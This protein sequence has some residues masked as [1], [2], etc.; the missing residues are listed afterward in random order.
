MNAYLFRDKILLKMAI[1]LCLMSYIFN[2]LYKFFIKIFQVNIIRYKIM[3]KRTLHFSSP[4]YLSMKNNQLVIHL[5]NAQGLDSLSKANTIPIED[6]GIVILSN[7]QITIT[8]GLI[9]KLLEHNVALV[10]CNDT[11]HPT[12][13][14]L[15][16]DGHT[17]QSARSK[18]QLEASEPLKKQL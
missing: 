15:N 9:A 4:A 8:H 6:I 2:L 16:L 18:A 17:L 1:L 11:H 12:G 5:P 14:M 10:T 13:L 7:Q 3:L